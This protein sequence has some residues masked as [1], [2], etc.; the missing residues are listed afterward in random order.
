MSWGSRVTLVLTALALLGA[1]V[2]AIHE[3][4]SG[5]PTTTVWDGSPAH[6]ADVTSTVAARS[7]LLPSS[8]TGAHDTIEVSGACSGTVGGLASCG[9]ATGNV[10]LAVVSPV[11]GDATLS[12][13]A[14]FNEDPLVQGPASASI[15]VE[16]AR[17]GGFDRWSDRAAT[18]DVQR[19][20][21][22]PL[23]GVQLAP[24]AGTQAPT[25]TLAGTARCAESS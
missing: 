19:N 21:D 25:V 7:C 2:L 6:L 3:G 17:V 24:E 11:D 1:T 12:I 20:G 4:R 14:Q 10:A 18:L 22:I 13:L 23:D 5:T 8:T 9:D 16:L 15:F